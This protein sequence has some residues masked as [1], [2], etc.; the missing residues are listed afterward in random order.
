MYHP[1]TLQD[2]VVLAGSV[3]LVSTQL[4]GPEFLL[5]V[6]TIFYIYHYERSAPGFYICCSGH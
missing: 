3:S 2:A 5:N 4:A 1:D 6:V